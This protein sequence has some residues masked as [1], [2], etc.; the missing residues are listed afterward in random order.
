MA[1]FSATVTS[2]TGQGYDLFG[3]LGVRL[4]NSE[5]ISGLSVNGTGSI[6][7]YAIKS[8]SDRDN[9]CRVKCSDSVST[10]MSAIGT[11]VVASVI[12]VSMFPNRDTSLTEVV[13]YINIDD[14]AVG[15][16]Y[17][18]SSLVIISYGFSEQ[19]MLV[20]DTIS[21]IIALSQ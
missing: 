1:L 21:E 6:F 4:L 5:R 15:L 20:S 13:T 14:I 3:G 10:I 7:Q 9:I 16:D 11:A 18:S 8:P 17:T 2:V 12:P 19:K